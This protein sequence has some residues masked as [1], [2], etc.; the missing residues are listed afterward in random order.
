MKIKA[1]LPFLS[2]FL[3]VSALN[4]QTSGSRVPYVIY[5]NFD[6]GEMFTWEPYPY[7][8]DT[9][10]DPL[11][12]TKKEPAFGGKGSSLSRLTKPN[13]A[14]DL[15]Q[16][17]TKR[18]DMYALNSTRLKVAYYFM[19]TEN[20]RSWMFPSGLSMANYS[21]IPFYHQRQMPGW[22]WISRSA[23]LV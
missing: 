17:F 23:L 11:F 1:I 9:G 21:P 7:Q 2:L 8:Q 20:Q 22:N 5:D 14:N 18:I 10:Y 12:G 15:T 13:D 19:T 6:T 4:A 16:G 3:F